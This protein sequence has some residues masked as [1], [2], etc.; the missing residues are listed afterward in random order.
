MALILSQR[1]KEKLSDDNHRITE[2]DIHQCFANVEGGFLIDDREEHRTDPPTRWFVS[3][4]DYG[5]R[6]KVMF[7]FRGQDIFIKSAYKA[8]DAVSDMYER[9]F[10]KSRG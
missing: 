10:V 2:S 4:N 9:K 5:V 8:T 7:I 6:I 3:Q 1:I